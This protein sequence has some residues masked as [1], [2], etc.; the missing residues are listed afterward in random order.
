MK[1]RTELWRIAKFLLITMTINLVFSLINMAITNG[2]FASRSVS[3]GQMLALLSY[4]HTFLNTLVLV[5]VHRYF[6]FRA[7]EKWYIAAPVM[8]VL[9]FLWNWAGNLYGIYFDPV[10]SGMMTAASYTAFTIVKGLLWFA[11][12]YALQR[13]VIYAHTTDQNGWYRRFHPTN[14]KG[15]YPNE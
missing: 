15:V 7:T 12:S 1:F 13:Y 6:T 9:A 2:P 4:A 11:V 14:D 3:T 8:I 5:L 10:S